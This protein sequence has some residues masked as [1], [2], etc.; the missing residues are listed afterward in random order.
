MIQ[1]GKDREEAKLSKKFLNDKG[2]AD[3]I[4]LTLEG[5]LILTTPA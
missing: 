4:R 1:A 3:I 5:S 2:E